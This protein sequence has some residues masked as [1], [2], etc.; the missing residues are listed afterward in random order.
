MMDRREFLKKCGC[1]ML[2]IPTASILFSSCASIHYA[3]VKRERNVLFVSKLEFIQIKKDE[4]NYRKYVLLKVPELG[5][6]ISLYRQEEDEYI[7][8]LLK[9]THRGCELNVGGDIY[10][11]PCHGSEFTIEGE[12]LQGPA[13]DNLTLFK[14]DSDSDNIYVYLS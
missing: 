9:C 10:S 14:T 2:A 7:A 8:T 5:F 6:P 4:K 1:A 11:C 13:E 12:D 3:E